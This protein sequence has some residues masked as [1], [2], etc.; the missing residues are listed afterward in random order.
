M[1]NTKMLEVTLRLYDQDRNL[2]ADRVVPYCGCLHVPNIVSFT[3]VNGDTVQGK[4][5]SSAIDSDNRIHYRF[6]KLKE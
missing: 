1:Y 4:L 6:D 2:V 5:H 3:D